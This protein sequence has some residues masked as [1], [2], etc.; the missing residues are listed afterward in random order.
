MVGLRERKGSAARA[1]GKDTERSRTGTE[2]GTGLMHKKKEPRGGPER[3]V[4]RLKKRGSGRLK[5][6][7]RMRG[8]SR[9]KSSSRM[10]KE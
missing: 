2:G 7:N 5:R 4:G 10:G 3:G 1:E 9:T 8:S 6:Q